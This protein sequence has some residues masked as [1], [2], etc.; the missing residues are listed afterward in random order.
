MIS[1]PYL[2]LIAYSGE[3][4]H[5]GPR[6]RVLP[7]A[8]FRPLRSGNVANDWILT[9]FASLTDEIMVGNDECLAHYIRD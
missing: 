4:G 1:V 5:C 3:D 7:S 6:T 9:A 8:L 2:G